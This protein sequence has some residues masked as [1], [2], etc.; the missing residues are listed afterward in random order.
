M[1]PILTTEMMRALEQH[2]FAHGLSSLDAMEMAGAAV[3][4]A[5]LTR[6]QPARALVL[7]GPG[8]NGG[9][10]FVCARYL[11]EAGWDV[12]LATWGDTAVMRG[13][14]ATMRDRWKGRS[15]LIQLLPAEAC[16]ELVVDALFGIGLTRPLAPVSKMAAIAARASLRVAVDIPSGLNADNGTWDPLFP[17]DV[18]ITFGAKKPGHLLLPGRLACG[19][20]S[21][22]GVGLEPETTTLFETARPQ[23]TEGRFDWHKYSRGAVLVLSGGM[24]STGASR[25]AARAAL[26]VGAGVVTLLCPPEAAFINACHLSAIMLKTVN[27]VEAVTSAAQDPRVRAVVL[28]PGFGIGDA[29]IRQVL[30]LLDGQAPLV[31]DA[32]ALTSF[33]NAPARLFSAGARRAA[34]VVMTPH[35]GEFVRLFPDITGDKLHRAQTAAAR[36]NAIVL[37]KGADTVIAAPD[38][39]AAINSNTSPWLATAGSGDVLA[40]IVAGLMAQGLPAWDAACGATWLHGEAGILGGRGLIAED[41]PELLPVIFKG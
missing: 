27:T 20:V 25:L 31:L 3:A 6:L 30:A 28:G 29:T 8:N 11:Y 19:M 1:Q 16:Y 26:R 12:T 34:P 9:D 17:A 7:C 2:R 18:T 22:A 32:D 38:G 24:T 15:S 35:E 4:Q 41:L 33:A 21:V 5:C 36:A 10:G 13:D 23:L 39:R 40:G 14:A 37:L